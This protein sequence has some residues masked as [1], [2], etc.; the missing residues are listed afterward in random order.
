MGEKKVV[1]DTNVI[2][3]GFGWNGECKKAIIKA[4][5]YEWYTSYDQIKEI[6]K[7]LTYPKLKNVSFKIIDFIKQNCKI[8][9]TSGKTFD[10]DMIRETASIINAIIV[11]GDK[12][13]LSF[14]NTISVR[15]FLEK[16]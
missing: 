15:E 12:E 2:I 6:E 1:L 11:T 9:S 13:F 8:I 5:D 10:D 16:Y 14:P 7:V 3:S 4:L